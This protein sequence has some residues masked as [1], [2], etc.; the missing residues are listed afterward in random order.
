LSTV[1]RDEASVARIWRNNP[2]QLLASYLI[3]GLIAVA[4]VAVSHPL[5]SAKAQLLWFPVAVFLAWRVSAGGRASRV[6]LLLVS[7]YSFASAAFT[8]TRLWSLGI[9]ALLAIYAT[10]VV[11]LVSPAVYQRTRRNAPPEWVPTVSMRWVPPLWMPL[12][13]LLTGVVA[14]L[15]SLAHMDWTAIPG[16]GPT[17][18]TLA[19]LPNRCFGLAQGYPVR[20]LTAYQSTPLIDKAGLV[21]DWAHWS[22][23]SFAVFY[24]LLLVHRRPEAPLDHQITA[25]DP[26]VA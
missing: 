9:L 3:L 17:G 25:E 6:I 4:V 15:L 10:Q 2:G 22:M 24:I 11:L 8:G 7:T 13:A 18:A 16:C 14:T 21:E 26:A 19:Q 23:V 5:P 12:F 1:E 20:F